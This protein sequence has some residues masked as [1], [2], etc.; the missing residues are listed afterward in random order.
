MARTTIVSSWMALGGL[1]TRHR[2]LAWEMVKREVTERFAGHWLG[3]V[4]AVGH[5]LIL[6]AVYV[7]IFTVI[8]EVRFPETA[9]GDYTVFILSGLVPWL[10]FQD[11]LNRSTQA[12]V[13]HASLVKQVVFPL[14]ILPIKMVVA[15]VVNQLVGWVV[16]GGYLAWSSGQLPAT[17]V[18]LPVLLAFQLI[19]ASGV[20]FLLAAITVYFRD[21]KEVVQVATF[22]ALWLTPVFYRTDMAPE[23]LRPLFYANPLSYFIWCYQDACFAGRI[24]EPLAWAVFPIGSVLIFLL[25]YSVFRR[26]RAGFGNLV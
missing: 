23:A 19:A 8:F 10:A 13:G 15:P 25:G 12:I 3:A 26:L 14:E 6:M 20:G 11:G 22:V 24:T 2:A 18:L 17:F 4:W 9:G 1:A 7:F 16:L 5:P 21:L